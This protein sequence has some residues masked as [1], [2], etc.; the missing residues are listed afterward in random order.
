MLPLFIMTQITRA[1]MIKAMISRTNPATAMPMIS[2]I[3]RLPDSVQ[4]QGKIKVL[5][6]KTNSKDCFYII[7][8]MYNYPCTAVF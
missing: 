5:D 1:K 3:L 6:D 7:H 8:N 2:L 4:R